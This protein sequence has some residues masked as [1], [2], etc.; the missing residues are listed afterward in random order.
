MPGKID[1]GA[2]MP[3][4]KQVIE[5]TL[6]LTP[7]RKLTNR[8]EGQLVGDSVLQHGSLGTVTEEPMLVPPESERTIFLLVDEPGAVLRVLVDE[9]PGDADRTGANP[10]TLPIA[11]LD[12]ASAVQDADIHPG[13]R[14]PFE[15]T[16]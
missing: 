16:G 4:S 1:L 13:W 5:P 14:K 9:G 8:S 12:P 11:R 3:E 10:Q 7:G 15:G 6:E 2:T